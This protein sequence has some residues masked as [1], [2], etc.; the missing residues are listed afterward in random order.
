M[1][2][3]CTNCGAHVSEAYR[4]VFSARGEDGIEA[5]PHCRDRVRKNGKPA[6]ATSKAGDARRRRQREAHGASQFDVEVAD[7]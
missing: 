7:D 6:N 2:L 5:C 1:S 4:R 3:S